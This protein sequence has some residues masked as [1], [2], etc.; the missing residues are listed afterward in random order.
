MGKTIKTVIAAA[1]TLLMIFGAAA[2]Q[3][4]TLNEIGNGDEAVRLAKLVWGSDFTGVDAEAYNWS[5]ETEEDSFQVSGYL[6]G[7]EGAELEM[8]LLRDGTLWSLRNY[9]MLAQRAPEPEGYDEVVIEAPKN[10]QLLS[11]LRRFAVCAAAKA[12]ADAEIIAFD[13]WDPRYCDFEVFL[14]DTYDFSYIVT[15]LMDGTPRVVAVSPVW[16]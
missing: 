15:L 7:E 14:G 4:F 11:L 3:E 13:S 6:D 2:A 16:G 10:E 8:T 5:T 12:P 1:M 9:S